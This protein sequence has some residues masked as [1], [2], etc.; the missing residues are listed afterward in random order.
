MEKPKKRIRLIEDIA[1]TLITSA[2]YVL[3]NVLIAHFFFK[4]GDVVSRVIPAIV[5]LVIGIVLINTS[6]IRQR[7]LALFPVISVLFI[8][9]FAA[10]VYLALNCCVASQTDGIK[11]IEEM[12]VRVFAYQGRDKEDKLGA[13]WVAD[14][15]ENGMLFREFVYSLPE[16]SY[17]YVGL[18]Y[19][20]TEPQNLT[21]YNYIEISANFGPGA[22][23]NLWLVDV[24][25]NKK[26]ILIGDGITPMDNFSVQMSDGIQVITIPL[27]STFSPVNL[28]IV[29]EL[30]FAVDTFLSRGRNNFVIHSIEFLSNK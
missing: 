26:E 9:S 20:F 22:V 6:W 17:G 12:P 3:I 5:M 23:C 24:D 2:V 16:E 27:E 10:N 8:I 7:M 4:R 1:V 25:G 15:K 19:K 18:V 11:S 21:E 29:S 30:D 28:R 13:A 14:I